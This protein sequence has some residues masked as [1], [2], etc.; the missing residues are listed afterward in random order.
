MWPFKK[1]PPTVIPDD[2]AEAQEMRTAATE[3]HRELKV[4]GQ[5]VSRLTSKLVERRALNHFGESI[6]ITFT[7]RGHA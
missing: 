3:Q 7:R 1:K 6:Q 2:V 5:E 4:Q